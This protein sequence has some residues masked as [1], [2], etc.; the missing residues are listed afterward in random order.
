M[1]IILKQH[2]FI[3]KTWKEYFKF[4]ILIT[5]AYFAI[6]NISGI[7]DADMRTL[8]VLANSIGIA[9]VSVGC[10]VNDWKICKFKQTNYQTRSKN[11]KLDIAIHFSIYLFLC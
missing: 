8:Y 6:P 5:S 7:A 2:R 10:T 3:A 11:I 9:Q 1:S 4:I